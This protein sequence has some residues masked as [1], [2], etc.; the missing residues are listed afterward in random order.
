M[1]WSSG[2]AKM[3]RWSG[4][5]LVKQRWQ[6]WCVMAMT[7]CECDEQIVICGLRVVER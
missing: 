2:V 6:R 3:V 5:V 4:V 7:W 1:R